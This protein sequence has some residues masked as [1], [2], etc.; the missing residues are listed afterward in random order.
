MYLAED[1]ILCFEL[2]A[3]R[4]SHWVLTYVCTAT[5]ETDVPEEMPELIKQRRRWL[6]GSFFAAVYALVHF[7]QIF[8]SSHSMMR[9]MMFMLEFLY[10]T[11]SMIFSWFAVANFFLVF[12]ILTTA[13]GGAQLLGR[14]GEVLSVI[15]EWVYLGS[16][17]VC[18]VLSLGNTPDGSRR[19][20]M[21]MVYSWALIMVYLL[22]ASWFITVKSVI[23]EADDGKFTLS[24]LFTNTIFFTLIVSLLSTYIL[25]IFASIVFMDPW[26]ILT[27]VSFPHLLSLYFSGVIN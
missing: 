20:Y 18:F 27:S 21:A 8:R 3:K 15:I 16:L 2:V 11:I 25:W 23:A 10:Q 13:L 17:V 24:K 7:Y 5:G 26:H 22:F 9:K 14:T 4:N 19:F 1:R 6:N 12:Q